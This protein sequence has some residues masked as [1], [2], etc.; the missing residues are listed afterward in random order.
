MAEGFANTFKNGL[1]VLIKNSKG[2][3]IA[4]AEA[5]RYGVGVDAIIGGRSQIIADIADYTQGGTAVERG[6]RSM[7]EKFGKVNLMDY[8]TTGVK[9]LH[10]VT[11]QNTLIEKLIKGKYDKR[12]AR[13]GI[14]EADAKLIAEQLKKHAEKMDGVIHIF[15][16]NEVP[17]DRQIGLIKQ[18][19]PL[20]IAEG[21]T[22]RY[23]GDVLALVVAESDAIAR[24][25][26][27]EIQVDYEVLIPVTDMHQAL[28]PDAPKI[29][30]EGN[31]RS[32]LR[33][34]PSSRQTHRGRFRSLD[35][36]PLDEGDVF[37][38]QL[39]YAAERDLPHH[40][41][42]SVNL[43]PTLERTSLFNTGIAVHPPSLRSIHHLPHWR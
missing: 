28:L 9:Q 43:A 7:A 30:P 22:T 11:M 3:K 16:A 13:L 31:Q 23:V 32:G 5:K 6:L 36:A 8:W 14:D 39:R 26:V 29:H 15:T 20:M 35:K 33:D 40:Q 34:V 17:G 41:P 2:F 18:D 19:W 38:Q 37:P 24:Q 42:P 10:A 1:G 12:L 4:A 21:E 25:A 27:A